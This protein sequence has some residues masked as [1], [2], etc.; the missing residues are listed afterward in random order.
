M[1]V[2]GSV[3]RQAPPTTICLSQR[4]QYSPPGSTVY[5]ELT[6]DQNRV[7]F[8]IQDKGIGIPIT[9]PLNQGYLETSASTHKAFA[10]IIASR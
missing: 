4:L 2:F 9:L 6:Y 5:F 3:G 8:R 10:V 1:I 7:T